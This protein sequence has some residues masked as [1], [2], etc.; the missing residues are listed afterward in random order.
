MYAI[1]SYYGIKLY[2]E[3]LL[4][5]FQRAGE[6][7]QQS[8]RKKIKIHRHQ[9]FRA[10]IVNAQL[11]VFRTD[12]LRKKSIKLYNNIYQQYIKTIAETVIN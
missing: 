4:A 6:K 5:G 10:G 7:A 8:F 1:R 2:V 9:C 11:V 12:Y 3:D